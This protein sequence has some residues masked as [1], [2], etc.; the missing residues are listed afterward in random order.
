M[1]SAQHLGDHPGLQGGINDTVSAGIDDGSGASGLAN[2]A[3]SSQF[4][5]INYLPKKWNLVFTTGILPCKIPVVNTLYLQNKKNMIQ[6][7]R[8]KQQVH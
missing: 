5:H 1:L 4:I 3:G 6:W 8:S 7:E 2:N